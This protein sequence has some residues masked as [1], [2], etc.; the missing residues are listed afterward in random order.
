M[1]LDSGLLHKGRALCPNCEQKGL[2][3]AGHPHAFGYKDYGK[4]A[5]RYCHER[6]KLTG[7]SMSE[8]RGISK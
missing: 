4:A 2:G 7:N 8:N 1:I 5:C 6:F 3:Y